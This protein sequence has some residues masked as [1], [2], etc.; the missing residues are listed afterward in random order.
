MTH[1]YLP[2][3]QELKLDVHL[4]RNMFMWQLC[5][6][7]AWNVGGLYLQFCKMLRCQKLF[8]G[9]ITSDIIYCIS[10]LN[11]RGWLL[12][13]TLS[14]DYLVYIEAFVLSSCWVHIFLC[15]CSGVVSIV[16]QSHP[17]VTVT[18]SN[19]WVDMLE[20]PDCNCCNCIECLM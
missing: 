20:F 13:F 3:S 19:L 2:T 6:V 12:K 17:V 18:R 5:N 11:S 1:W 14:T 10:C 8:C 4:Q 7:S 9:I 16:V 15:R